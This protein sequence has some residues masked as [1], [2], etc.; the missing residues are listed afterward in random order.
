MCIYRPSQLKKT[1]HK[2]LFTQK[3]H[4]LTCV[5]LQG[6]KEKFCSTLTTASFMF[7]IANLMPMQFRGP[8]PKGRY[9]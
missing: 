7:T 6:L 8:V 2:S 1:S 3:V 4:C 9:V 5:S